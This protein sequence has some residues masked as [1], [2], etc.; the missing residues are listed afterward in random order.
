MTGR[1]LYDLLSVLQMLHQ[2]RAHAAAEALAAVIRENG[3]YI[4]MAPA[5]A[6]PKPAPELPTWMRPGA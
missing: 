4:P 1:D 6:G 3:C 5:I 2:G